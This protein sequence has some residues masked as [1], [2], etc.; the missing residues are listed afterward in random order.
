MASW[1]VACAILAAGAA[2]TDARDATDCMQEFSGS[3]KK[4]TDTDA[5]CMILSAFGECNKVISSSDALRQVA[6][7]LYNDRK[8]LVP[9]CSVTSKPTISILNR[10]IRVVSE[11]DVI[12]QRYKRDQIGAFQLKGIVEDQDA[13]L[14]AYQASS[15]VRAEKLT[16][17][18]KDLGGKVESAQQ[19]L[20]AAAK[21]TANLTSY[22]IK[23][24]AAQDQKLRNVLLATDGT[25]DPLQVAEVYFLAI[26]GAI[27]P[28]DADATTVSA[29]GVGL[30]PYYHPNFP[31]MFKCKFTNSANAKDTTT[32]DGVVVKDKDSA[33]SYGVDCNTPSYVKTKTSYVLSVT[34]NDNKGA[35]TIPFRGTKGRDVVLFTM[36]WSAVT[37]EDNLVNVVV[38][39]FNP[40]KKYTCT[41]ELVADSKQKKLVQA[42]FVQQNKSH[43]SCGKQPVFTG[44]PKTGSTIAVKLTLAALG[45]SDTAVFSGGGSNVVNF[46][47][48]K[49][50]IQDGS[51]SDVDCGGACAVKCPST[52][53]CK[54][55][56]DCQFGSCSKDKKCGGFSGVSE[57][58]A[59][60]SCKQIKRDYP[61]AKNGKY[62]LKGIKQILKHAIVAF[63]WMEGREGGGWTLFMKN[64]YAGHKLGPWKSTV[65]YGSPRTCDVLKLKGCAYK[66]HDDIIRA[67]IGQEDAETDAK[68]DVMQDQIGTHTYYSANNREYTVMLGYEAAWNF[69]LYTPVP[70]SKSKVLFRSYYMSSNFN[71][72]TPNGD[73]TINWEGQLN[74]GRGGTAGINCYGVKSYTKGYNNQPIVGEGCKTNP[75]TNRWKG[76]L[77]WYMMNGNHDTYT[78][79][80]NGAQHSSGASMNPRFWIRSAT[81]VE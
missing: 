40:T 2:A 12:F 59:G 6:I 20:G 38:Q 45:S 58:F 8:K 11:Q 14:K 49:N 76:T 57:K 68:F 74:C 35:R 34:Y 79:V 41:F 47:A 26:H 62:W 52:K 66:M 51:E 9:E 80:C 56:T 16:E 78:Y 32:T 63:C 18:V 28:T 7:D 65:G 55:D 37:F 77:H 10:D 73:G 60:D 1:L 29:L 15:K 31:S 43:L 23:V 50:G 25:I 24:L 70:E 17:V 54:A 46:D 64:W 42:Y 39:G 5:K 53:K 3:F 4:A 13:A 72:K 21:Q 71:G 67:V 44:Q 19:N 33:D 75:S 81:G 61:K 36:T 69:I 22:V 27:Q 30:A 48:C